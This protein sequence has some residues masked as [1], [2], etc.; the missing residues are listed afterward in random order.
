MQEV[1]ESVAG[2]LPLSGQ[3]STVMDYGEHQVTLG[4]SQNIIT[5]STF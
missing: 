1:P 2:L 3:A 4:V 5:F